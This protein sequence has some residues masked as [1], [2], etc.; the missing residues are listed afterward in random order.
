[1]KCQERT[2]AQDWLTHESGT[3]Q[4]LIFESLLKGA[5]R[6]KL[7]NNYKIILGIKSQKAFF[8]LLSTTTWT[9]EPS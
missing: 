9:S 3:M 2:T 5:I 4:Y 1:V 7:I 8:L 6:F